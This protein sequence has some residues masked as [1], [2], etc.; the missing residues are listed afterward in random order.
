VIRRLTTPLLHWTGAVRPSG[1]AASRRAHSGSIAAAWHVIFDAKGLLRASTE[2]ISD[3]ETSECCKI[4]YGGHAVIT[5]PYIRG[6]SDNGEHR[7]KASPDL[8]NGA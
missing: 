3:R 8:E 6:M 7:T 4:D 2:V 1:A 5:I